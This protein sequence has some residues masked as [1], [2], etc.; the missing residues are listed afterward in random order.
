MFEPFQNFLENTVKRHGI[1]VE[2]KAATV[3]HDFRELLPRLFDGTP[4][5]HLHIDALSFKDKILTV[6]VENSAWG[7]EVI[8]RKEKI[9]IEIN[10]KAGKQII[11]NLRTQLMQAKDDLS[12]Q[13]TFQQL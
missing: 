13:K 6:S 12:D 8:M 11:K 7:Q 9:I 1:A 4:H 5:P 10:K 2:A 3:C